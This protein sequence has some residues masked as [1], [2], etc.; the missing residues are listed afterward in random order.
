MTSNKLLIIL[1][2]ILFSCKSKKETIHPTV[3]SISESI[4][5][6][7]LLKSKDQYQAYAKANGIVEAIFVTEGDSVK[8]EQP[9]LSISNE[10]QKLIKDNAMLSSAFADF[11]AN[12]GKLNEAKL[13]LELAKNKMQNDSLNYFRQS[14]L[15]QQQIGTKAEL[16]QRELW[17]QNSKSNYY[18]SKVQYEDL[19][20]QLIFSSS[21]AKKNLSIATKQAGDFTLKSEINGIVYN[22]PISKGEIV[23]AQTPLAVIG[24]AKYFILEMQVDEYDILKIRKGLTVLVTMD[25]YKGS[26]FEAVVTKI[27]PIMNERSKTILVEAEFK[28]PP[29]IL[30]PNISFE[31]NIIVQ[32]KKMAY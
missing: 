14:A 28:H 13:S 10:T 9:I 25:S 2:F 31:A 15:W 23:S 8:K 17:Y 4:Y 16:E 20:R 24:D 1:T 19:K 18:S 32:T 22:I 11:N 5:A 30:Y 27:N 6:S 3:E 12:Q 26:V 29:P 21:Q 7:G